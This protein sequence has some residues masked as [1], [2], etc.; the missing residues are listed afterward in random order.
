GP[1]KHQTV[2]GWRA[3]PSGDPT[4]TYPCSVNTYSPTNGTRS[5]GDIYQMTGDWYRRDLAIDGQ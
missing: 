1:D 2:N 5:K 4:F 3:F